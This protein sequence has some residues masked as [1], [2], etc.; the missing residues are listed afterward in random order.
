[1]RVLT[2]PIGV[3]GGICNECEGNNKRLSLGCKP[4]SGYEFHAWKKQICRRCGHLAAS[5]SDY[6]G[7]EHE[8]LMRKEGNTSS[9][10]T[11]SKTTSTREIGTGRVIPQGRRSLEAAA[12]TTINQGKREFPITRRKSR[13]FNN[14][15]QLREQN[16]ATDAT[17]K[18]SE[19]PTKSGKWRGG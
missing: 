7:A 17:G 16:A 18:N 11:A 10:D 19:T 1:M 6:K 9:C 8:E 2:F 5:H 3:S 15:E 13:S 14:L 12:T 4:C